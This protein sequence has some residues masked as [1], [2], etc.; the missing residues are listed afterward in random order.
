MKRRAVIVGSKGQDGQLLADLL[1]NKGYELVLVSRGQPDITNASDVSNLVSGTNPDEIYFLAAHHH[2]SEDELESD[3]AI[4]RKSSDIHVI[5]AVNFLEAIASK[6]PTARFFYASSS[7]IFPHST[8]YLLDEE[9]APAP[10]NIYAITKH[11]GMMACRFYRDKRKVFASCGVLFNHESALRS[12]KYLSRKVAIAAATISKNKTGTLVL[13]D[14]DA[15][16]DWGHA[17]DYVEAMHRVLQLGNPSDY[18]I[19]SGKA[20]TVRQF[21]EIAF[22]HVGLDYMAH[23]KVRPDL[24]SK[25]VETRIGNASRLKADTGW[26]PTVSFEAMVMMMVDAELAPLS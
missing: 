13:G 26:S 24:L 21:V 7:H 8:G 1:R 6:A 20:H 4:F 3:E 2:S 9:T 16:V 23:V 5:S 19:A 18:V 17:P 11:S 12:P 10:E 15:L 14:L 25:R 22:S